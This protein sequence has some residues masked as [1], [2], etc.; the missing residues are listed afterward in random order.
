LAGAGVLVLVDA[1]LHAAN[2]P[3]VSVTTLRSPPLRRSVR[4]VIGL[5]M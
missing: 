3:P 5:F 4:R 2:T 1:L